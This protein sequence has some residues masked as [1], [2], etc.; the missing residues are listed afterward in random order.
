MRDPQPVK[1]LFL[2]TVLAGVGLA[3]WWVIG[4]TASERLGH[5]AAVMVREHVPTVP[6]EGLWE[7]A[8]WLVTHRL[9]QLQ[10]MTG[11]LLVAVLGG[12]GEGI[13]RR[14]VDVLGGFLLRLWTVG[15]V[16]LALLPGAVAGYLLAPWPLPAR[17]AA[18]GLAG[19]VAVSSYG[20]GAGRPY[21]P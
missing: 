3:A 2:L 5:L 19:L 11:V 6:P 13:A 1:A 7:Q 18:G 4:L 12:S 16:G 21:V 14:R 17:A 20:V 8:V 9:T 10:G 15:V